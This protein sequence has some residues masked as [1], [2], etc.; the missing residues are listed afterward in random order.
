ML[1][2]ELEDSQEP[3]HLSWRESEVAALVRTHGLVTASDVERLLGCAVTN[4]TVRNT[5]NR[6][7]QKRILIRQESGS[8]RALVYASAMTPYSARDLAMEQVAS[9]FYD[10]SLRQL[11]DAL[12][13]VWTSIRKQ[14]QTQVISLL[15][16]PWA[17][18][19]NGP[20]QT[21]VSAIDGVRIS[22]RDA[23]LETFALDYCDGSLERLTES[24]AA[25]RA[26]SR[27]RAT[28]SSGRSS[29]RRH[30]P[31]FASGVRSVMF[32]SAA[33]SGQ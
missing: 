6:L 17:N 15:Q 4:A 22:A 12:A 30:V 29:R 1:L 26:T 23:A 16:S 33:T 13:A 24:L 27:K 21:R 5:L 9:D 8:D 19:R 14:R 11:T 20:D 3:R 31:A 25:L 18:H 28:S 7:V 2:R 10:G 32:G